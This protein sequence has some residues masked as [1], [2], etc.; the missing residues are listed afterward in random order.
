MPQP[1]GGVGAVKTTVR[2]VVVVDWR[3]QRVH[4]VTADEERARQSIA[5]LLGRYGG[6]NLSASL[7]VG[8]VEV[9]Q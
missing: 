1:S 6:D 8:L 3:R 7:T 2:V 9:D 4:T 5:E